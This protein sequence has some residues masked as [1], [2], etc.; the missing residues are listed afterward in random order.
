MN[1]KKKKTLATKALNVGRKRI[2]FVDLRLDEIKDAITKQDIKQLKKEG[3]II[4][5]EVKGRR[6][7]KKKSHKRGPGNVK[8]KVKKRKQEYIIMTRKLRKYLVELK[9]QGKVSKEDVKEYRKK[10]RNKLFKSK[11]HLKE[12]IK[13]IEK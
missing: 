4:V 8:K 10:I 6:K 1:L 7:V 11:A 3:A 9:K 12:Q 2:V 5:K 13:I